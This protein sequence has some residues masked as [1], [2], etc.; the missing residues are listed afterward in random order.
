[1]SSRLKML[2]DLHEGRKWHQGRVKC[3]QGVDCYRVGKG[4]Q[5][6]KSY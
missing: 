2:H 1:M 4:R 6:R 3:D 5:G